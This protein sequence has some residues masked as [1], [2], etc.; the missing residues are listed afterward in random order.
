[1]EVQSVLITGAAG[2]LGSKLRRHLEGRYQLKLL[3]IDPRGDRAILPA[4]VGRWNKAWVDQLHGVDVVVHLAANPAAHQ[5]WPDVVGPNIDGAINL[6]QAAV[7]R[8]VKRVVYASSNHVMGGYKDDPEPPRLTTDIPP[9]P[10]TRYEVNG[11]SRNST[12]YAAAKLF[13]ERLG[14]CY[15]DACGLSLIAVRIGWVRPGE[16]RAQDVPPERGPWFRLMWLSNRDFCQLM[17]RCLVADLP[18]LF[19]VVNGMSANAGMR[20]DIEYTRQLVG[21]APC[22]DVSRPA[23]V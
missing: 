4:D 14:K 11:E 1:M 16:N 17:E 8:G 22:D 19:A 23:V 21:Y 20:W 5:S 2:N 12:P 6:F 7:Q 15:A 10:G 18:V 13:G 3:D 9:R